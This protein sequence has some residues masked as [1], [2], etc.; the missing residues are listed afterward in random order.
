MDTQSNLTQFNKDAL[1]GEERIIV[2][3]DEESAYYRQKEIE[4][5]ERLAREEIE[6]TT[7]AAQ[8]QAILDRLGLTEEEAQLL[9]GGN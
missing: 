6:K 5:I 3:S 7:R 8:R 1:T 4:S 2:L 9:L